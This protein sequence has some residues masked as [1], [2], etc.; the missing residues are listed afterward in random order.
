[1]F[2]GLVVAAG[3]GDLGAD[4]GEVA[5]FVV[6]AV[7]GLESDGGAGDGGEEEGA[8]LCDL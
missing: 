2:D 1:L 3:G 5:G 6:F 4:V 7:D 8:D